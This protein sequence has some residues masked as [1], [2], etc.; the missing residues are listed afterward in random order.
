MVGQIPSALGAVEGRLDKL[1]ADLRSEC[2]GTAIDNVDAKVE[3]AQAEVTELLDQ[4][5][6]RETATIAVREELHGSL[7]EVRTLL[8][9]GMRRREMKRALV[10]RRLLDLRDVLQENLNLAVERQDEGKPSLWKK[11]AGVQTQPKLAADELERIRGVLEEVLRT[12][13]YL[14]FENNQK[15]GI[16]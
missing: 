8:K 14:V 5:V 9:E 3:T 12:V 4:V 11:V 6:S 15:D 10:R 7:D 1:A 2:V 13:E 16:A